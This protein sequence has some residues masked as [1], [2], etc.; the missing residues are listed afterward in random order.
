[1]QRV[2]RAGGWTMLG[3][4]TNQLLRLAG[5]LILTRLLFPDA[6]GLM[7]IVQAVIVGVVMFSDVGIEQSIIH[8]KRGNE[9]AFV[10]TA[11]SVKVIRGVLMWLALWLLAAPLAS[12]YGEPMLARLLPVAGLAAVISGFSSTK[13]AS[14]DRDL[15]IAR[16]T[17]IGVGSYAFGL[18]VM[19]VWASID[20]SIWS[21][22]M[23]NIVGTAAQAIASHVWLD[24]IKNR[25]AWESKSLRSLRTFGQ[26]I[27]VSSALTFLVGEG[28]RLL[29]AHFLD[30]RMLAFFSLALAMDQVPR[31]IIQQM[32][33]RVLFPAYSEVVRERPEKLYAIVEKSRLLQIVPYWLVCVFLVYFGQSLMEILYDDR[34]HDS[35]WMLQIMA[36]GSLVG[37]L[38]ISYNG[39]LWAKGMV[40]MSTV[41]LAIQLFIQVSAIVVG[42]YLGGARGL[43]LGWALTSWLLYPVYAFVY[44]RLSLWQPKL[45]LPLIAASFWI[46]FSVL[47]HTG[48]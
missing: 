39:I 13:I 4:G 30:V 22:V 32:T 46:A 38:A 7:A 47:G 3:Y 16:T 21:L 23:G 31:Q 24:G 12:F 42:S 5:N 8:N 41:L 26:W 19:I 2:L 27:F 44:S 17:L 29:I 28:S 1:V 33:G 15:E 10:N 40:R 20:R 18:L 25:F 34:Y 48:W 9:P 6:F 36:L 37:G 11:W 43:V 35:G 14:A 45:D